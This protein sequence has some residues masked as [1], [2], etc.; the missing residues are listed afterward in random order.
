MPV[1]RPQAVYNRIPTRALEGRASTVRARQTLAELAIP[2]Y[3]PSYFHKSHIYDMIRRHGLDG[4]LP[5]TRGRL[6]RDALVT[7][8]KSHQAVYL[9]PAAAAS[10]MG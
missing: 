3:N 5:D 1:P 4:N 6:T 7:M 10:G 8:L 9:K 2:M